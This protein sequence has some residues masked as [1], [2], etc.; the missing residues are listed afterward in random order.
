VLDEYL[1]SHR[2]V[3]VETREGRIVMRSDKPHPR[4]TMVTLGFDLT[5]CRIFDGLSGRSR[6]HA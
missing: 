5:Q 6:A 3:H 2:L 1:G 4:G